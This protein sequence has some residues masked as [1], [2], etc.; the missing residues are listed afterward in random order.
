M[1]NGSVRVRRPWAVAL[2]TVVTVG[3]YWPIWYFKINRELRDVGRLGHDESL[4]ASSPWSSVAA[5]TL[6]ALVLVPPFVSYVRF[7]GRLQ[8]GERAAGV[9]PRASAPIA[10]LLVGLQV[11]HLVVLRTHG[12]AALVLL[13]ITFALSA[14]AMVL[15]QVRMNAVA[16]ALPAEPSAPMVAVAA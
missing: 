10:V 14:A 15:V 4:A 6:G 5:I 9:K 7:A 13:A 1:S 11:L 2:L 12:S 3:I 8:D 16:R